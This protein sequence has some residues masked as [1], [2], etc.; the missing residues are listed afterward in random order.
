MT[1]S[2][3]DKKISH[4][5]K[6]RVMTS[7]RIKCLLMMSLKRKILYDVTKEKNQSFSVDSAT[8]TNEISPL[9]S[10]ATKE[11]LNA[12]MSK[13]LNELNCSKTCLMFCFML[14]ICF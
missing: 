1:L 7:L 10:G 14:K 8:S 13:T 4:K 9:S 5:R 11:T 12:K 3:T 2:K 6:V